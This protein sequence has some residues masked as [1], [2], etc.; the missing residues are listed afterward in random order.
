MLKEIDE[1]SKI[2][3]YGA[4]IIARAVIKI[5][6]KDNLFRDR[7][8]G[9]A[10]T[11][12]N[13]NEKEIDG[14][15][16]FEA[17]EILSINREAYVVV[18]VRERYRKDIE[19]TIREFGIE[20]YSYI[21]IDECI[22]HLEKEL[23]TESVSKGSGALFVKY[24]GHLSKEEYLMF[25]S[26]QLNNDVLNFEV[27]VVDHCNLNCQ[28]CNHFSPLA[29]KKFLNCTEYERDIQRLALITNGKIGTLMLLG[30]EPLLHPG[31]VSIM[32]IS[33]KHL[34]NTEISI[35]SNG[36]LL[37]KMD[38]AFWQACREFDI[39]I[40]LT[41]YPIGFDYGAL[42][43]RALQEK[44]SLSYAYESQELKTS[45]RLPLRDEG[46]LNPYINYMKCYHA[47]RC[48]VLREGRLYT[49]PI[50][51]YVHIFNRYFGKNMPEGDANSIDIYEEDSA[52]RLYKF[53]SSPIP[54]CKH[55][56]IANYEYN[57]PWSTS[58]RQLSEW[59]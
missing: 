15:K 14:V 51:A 28:C 42:E 5:L 59:T 29:E 36:L 4:G 49:C 56:D 37:G 52:E 21:E 25:L 16:V 10:V 54:M 57:I 55:C 50:S 53:L 8:V 47:K 35:V 13:Y 26:K 18:A 31:I 20:K 22:E 46:E 19:K 7:I 12:V 34:R 3:I 24:K 38:A 58:K 30:G 17:K 48:V 45:W 41:K 43:K 23:L 44:V 32:Q 1:N 27:N 39:H 6:G 40:V 33:R 2:I 11:S 9:C